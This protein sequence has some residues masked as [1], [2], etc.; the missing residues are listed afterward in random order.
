MACSP[1]HAG[2]QAID[3]T[4]EAPFYYNILLITLKHIFYYGYRIRKKPFYQ[5]F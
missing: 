1:L 4:I 3:V 5:T 2:Q